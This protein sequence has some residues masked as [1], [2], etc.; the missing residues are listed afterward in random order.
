MRAG[1]IESMVLFRADRGAPANDCSI[2]IGAQMRDL[3]C[4]QDPVYVL[5]LGRASPIAASSPWLSGGCRTMFGDCAVE[6]ADE[7]R[8]SCEALIRLSEMNCHSCLV[9]GDSLRPNLSE[10]LRVRLVSRTPAA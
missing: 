8:R 4:Q 6:S 9:A 7:R 1:D 10:R 2:A 5:R 3:P